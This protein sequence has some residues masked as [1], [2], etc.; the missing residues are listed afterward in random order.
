MGYTGSTLTFTITVTNLG[1]GDATGV[2]VTDNLP[3]EF[4]FASCASTGGGVCGGTGNART[5]TFATLAAGA[6]AT[7]TLDTIV[8][9]NTPLGAMIGNTASVAAAS[10]GD[11]NNTDNSATVTVTIV[12]PPPPPPPPVE[13]AVSDVV[14]AYSPNRI[15]TLVFPFG[16][17]ITWTITNGTITSGQGTPQIT[18]TAG[19]PGTL[20][21]GVTESNPPACYSF[22][23]STFV[24]VAPAGSAVLHYTLPPCRVLDTRGA[25]GPL[26]GP[27]LAPAGV[28]DRT[29]PVAGACGIP[30]DATTISANVTVTNAF[31]AGSLVLYPGDG[32]A[33]NTSTIS[34]AANQTRANN[35]HVRLA[36]D[37]SGTLRIQNTSPGTV[38][39]VVDV[40]GYYR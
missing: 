24:T 14:G 5:V 21:L 16:S 7:V 12:V 35:A 29:F 10:P 39:V 25:P 13:I 1:P 34:F 22:Q 18:F 8:A 30:A 37:G 4:V 6:S 3:P 31:D 26:G 36:T 27:S 15:A 20:S 33:P 32:M 9:C 28:L 2:V 38:D 11:P 23:G 40:T 19:A 17:L